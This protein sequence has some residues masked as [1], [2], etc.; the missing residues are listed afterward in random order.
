[1]SEPVV[2][3]YK[4]K[5]AAHNLSRQSTNGSFNPFAH[6]AWGQK[7]RQT[8]PNNDPDLESGEAV[9]DGSPI[10]Q[11]HTAPELHGSG[12]LLEDGK[13]GRTSKDDEAL[14]ADPAGGEHESGDTVVASSVA[15]SANVK[16][17][18]VAKQDGKAEAPSEEP[19]EDDSKD[20]KKKKE[21]RFL[22]H[23]E[24][25]EPF[26]F[27][28]QLQRTFLNS[29]INVLLIAAPVG[30]GLHFT[31]VTP[32][33]IFVVNFIAIIPLAAMLSFATEEIALRTGET[34]GGLLNATFGYEK[35]HP[36]RFVFFLMA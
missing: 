15:G 8:F 17:R 18:Q 12:A 24:P 1:M 35:I 21:S 4:I 25:K 32:I 33:V 26:T 19:E 31:K 13:E 5:R 20:K 29:W 10:S 6:V 16:K 22:K 23:V 3:H 28:N 27:V 30:I 9:D 2:N 36:G 34:L 7:R 11:I 14:N